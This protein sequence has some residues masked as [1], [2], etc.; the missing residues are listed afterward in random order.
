MRAGVHC[1]KSEDHMPQKSG[2][3]ERAGRKAHAVECFMGCMRLIVEAIKLHEKC[4]QP[5]ILHIPF[6]F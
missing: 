3:I 6:Q 5:V 1:K 2:Y 4:M